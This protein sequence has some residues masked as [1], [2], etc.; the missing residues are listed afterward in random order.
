M[1]SEKKG[2]WFFAFYK[3]ADA[4]MIDFIVN[5]DN[6]QAHN[7]DDKKTDIVISNNEWLSARNS[8]SSTIHFT[9]SYEKFTF[10]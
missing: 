4:E 7:F 3:K 10:A 5:T 1:F 2:G 6:T 8:P 9:I